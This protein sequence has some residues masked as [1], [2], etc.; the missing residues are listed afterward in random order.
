MPSKRQNDTAGGNILIIKN[1]IPTGCNGMTKNEILSG[2]T[3]TPV[4]ENIHR[5]MDV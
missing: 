5:F 4:M 2:D 1:V 3:A